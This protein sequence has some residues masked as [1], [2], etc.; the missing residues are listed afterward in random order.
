[1]KC[2]HLCAAAVQSDSRSAID[3][4]DTVLQL[5]YF[6]PSADKF[7]MKAWTSWLSAHPHAHIT[8]TVN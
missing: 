8:V 4:V 3:S 1:M 2:R 7:Y 6:S 5:E